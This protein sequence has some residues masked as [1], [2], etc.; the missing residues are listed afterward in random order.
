MKTVHTEQEAELLNALFTHQSY[1]WHSTYRRMR[2]RTMGYV[3][4]HVT[5]RLHRS[6][7]NSTNTKRRLDY[8]LNGRNIFCQNIMVMYT[9]TLYVKM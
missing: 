3:V 6:L 9:S 7:A 5:T 4:S 1:H 2:V 8:S